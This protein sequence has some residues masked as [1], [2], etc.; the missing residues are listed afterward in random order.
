MAIRFSG[1][2]S[3][4]PS[5]LLATLV[6]LS[7]HAVLFRIQAM[8][9]FLVYVSVT[10]ALFIS[11]NGFADSQPE[12]K[13]LWPHGAPGATGDNDADKPGVWVYPAKGNPN[14]AAIVICPG[15]GYAIHATDH[16]GVQP[17]RY[18]NS[19]GVTA[20]VL[21]YRLSPYRHPA[22]L[23]DAQRAI[24]FVRAN[25]KEFGV[26]PHR[27]GIMGFSAGGHL[28]STA[29][30]HF[31]AGESS[32]VDPIDQ[33]SCRPDFGILGYPVVSF[34]ADYAHKGSAK[35]LLG[36]NPT[37]EQLNEL[38]NDTQVTKE[39]PPI[40]LFH[41]SEDTGVPPANSLAFYA[42]CHK[43][44]VSAE[45]HIYQH[46]PH[47]VGLANEHPALA[48]WIGAAGTW[49]RQNALLTNGKRV[50]VSGMVKLKGEPLKFGTIAFKPKDEHAPVGWAMIRN[51]QFAIPAS[52]GPV[53]G[54][55]NAAV[56]DMGAVAPEPTVDDAKL[57][58]G[59]I[60]VNVIDGA[61]NKFDL[62]FE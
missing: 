52:S 21:R 38:S 45:L 40:F 42:A 50:A 17:A 31:D 60:V 9:Q 48:N 44:G 56:T 28:T 41:T 12:F 58:P 15:G 59:G 18:F 61:E 22:P 55:C 46:G 30:T 10:V 7:E 54:L 34:V 19:I 35:N 51:G 5:T 53:A 32:A 3:E 20:F 1:S 25:A 24:R 62:Q 26:D 47:G 8:K 23:H 4:L 2:E 43:A 49:L 27:V 29:V 13:F 36:D 14:G 16:E 37:D 57:L 33:Q 6:G 11:R 39:T